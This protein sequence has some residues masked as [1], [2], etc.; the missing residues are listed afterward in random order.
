MSRYSNYKHLLGIKY[1]AGKNDCYGLAFDLYKDVLNIKLKNFA[2]PEGF[3][4]HKDLQIINDLM[5]ADRWIN[6]GL[7]TKLLQFGDV[8]AFC[9]GSKEGVANHLGIYVGNGM[10]IHHLLNRMSV[11]E[12]LLD[13]WKTRLLMIGRHPETKIE[14]TPVNLEDLLPSYAKRTLRNN[15]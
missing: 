8:L 7:N 14:T 13:K 11:E 9:I 2:R 3:Y 10:F 12:P 5:F 15:P 6:K 1:K 4:Q